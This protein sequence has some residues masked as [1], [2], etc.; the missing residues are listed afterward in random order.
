MSLHFLFD[1]SGDF[2]NE[3]G[4]AAIEEPG[5][6]AAPSA[7]GLHDMERIRARFPS[8]RV[9]VQGVNSAS[10]RWRV[11]AFFAGSNMASCIDF[12]Q[13]GALCVLERYISLTSP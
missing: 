11:Y 2:Y 4:L 7:S 3:A 12:S 13:G 8:V 5:A 10:M 6:S 9:I 1:I